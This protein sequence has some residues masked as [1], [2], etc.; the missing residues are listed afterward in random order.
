MSQTVIT[1]AFETLKA[2]EAANGGVVT[3]DEFVF[4]NVPD[5]N[6]TDPID[7]T[8][9]LP[10]ASQIVHRQAVSKTGMVNSNAVVYSV[11]LGADVGDFEF[12]WVG[13]LN[14]A[15]GVIAMI[16][17]AP[18]QKKIKTES[19]QQGNV[20]TRSFLME[21]N[22]ASQQTQ[23]ITPADTWQIDFTARLNGVD[24]RI[25]KENIDMYGVASFINDAF[26]VSGQNGVYQVNKGVAYIEGV[27]AELLF[28]QT[29]TVTDK[30]SKIWVDVCWQ[31]TLT[32]VWDAVSTITVANSL[33]NYVV[34][35]EQ[36]YVFAVAE[37]LADGSIVDL[38]PS[39]AVAQFSVWEAEADTI[40]YFDETTRLNKTD[41]SLFGRD[42]IAMADTPELVNRLGLGELD[43]QF[44]KQSRVSQVVTVGLGGDF[45]SL[46]EA[47]YSVSEMR[48]VLS[49]GNTGISVE[50]LPGFILKEQIVIDFADLS[51]ITITS[52]DV[53]K[54]DRL[55]LT[56]PIG[57]Y[58]PALCAR[59]GAK[60]PVVD[61]LFD[62]QRNGEEQDKSV[63]I[64]ASGAGSSVK[65][66][67]DKGC[68]NS[69]GAGLIASHGA[70][71]DAD[72]SVWNGCGGD[73]VS[74]YAGATGSVKYA[75]AD[76]C[77][78]GFVAN[79]GV[80]DAT[81]A[82]AQSTRSAGFASRKSGV[83]NAEF[84]DGQNGLNYG[85]YAAVSSLLNVTRGNCS[86][87][88]FGI[89]AQR[90]SKIAA[91]EVIADNCT[92]TN[93]SARR[94][95]EIE[96]QSCHAVNTTTTPLYCIRANYSGSVIVESGVIGGAC[97]SNICRATTN[98]EIQ[99]TDCVMSG[100]TGTSIGIY[101]DESS[102]FN[103]R[104]MSL[105]HEL[106]GGTAVQVLHGSTADISDST[107]V[108]GGN[109]GIV[110]Q[111]CANI[112]ADNVGVHGSA[113]YSVY[114]CDGGKISITNANVRRDIAVDQIT[115]V[116]VSRGGI[117]SAHG[118]TGGVNTTVNT[119]SASGT[120]YR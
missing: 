113:N 27:R 57:D 13:L 92:E 115:D 77:Y 112:S 71:F 108:A 118:V 18:S 3:L 42:I 111:Y 80:L 76:R 62:M 25:R 107:I 50:L 88:R 100:A 26:L 68:I 75:S 96:A 36:H 55:A 17:H 1:Q 29:V 85:F 11:V 72:Y 58:Y 84:A 93:I 35:D 41:I 56:L 83:L 51:F 86:G 103:G 67:A 6:I 47:I 21:Y 14:K 48:Y 73:G 99:A 81:S 15:N 8:E 105:N 69:F 7:R 104:R 119:V 109:Y 98:A 66:N 34:E 16:V 20:L 106:S 89:S 74:V 5:L 114:A 24:E 49:K 38:R 46:S 59:N 30:P 28:N 78:N 82:R 90:G 12:N 120:I 32:S 61:V 70:V 4:A 91:E 102:N 9:G 63:A 110:S 39:N 65:V 64:F 22:G 97:T 45:S 95:S 40:P 23:I 37:V 33:V 43:S 94:Y 60:F 10:P 53:V 2:Q 87:S 79:G 54:I 31:G 44:I 19:G 52:K 101:V 117:I 116:V